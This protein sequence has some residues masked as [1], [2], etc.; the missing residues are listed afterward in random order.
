[1]QKEVRVLVSAVVVALFSLTMFLAAFFFYNNLQETYRVCAQFAYDQRQC[2]GSGESIAVSIASL[3]AGIAWFSGI[4]LAA[5]MVAVYI[6]V[7]C[8]QAFAMSRLP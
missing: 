2:Y 5:W 6:A 3:K 7:K 1:M 4:G 8:R